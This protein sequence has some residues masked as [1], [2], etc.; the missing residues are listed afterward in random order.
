MREFSL[1]QKFDVIFN[2]FT[3]FGYF[4]K[5]EENREVLR[6]VQSHLKLNGHL[7]LDFLNVDHVKSG[8][9]SSEIKNLDGIDFHIEKKI[10]DGIIVKRIQ[11]RDES[12]KDHTYHERVQALAFADFK[13]I[14]G[15]TGM[16]IIN[17]FGDYNLNPFDPGTSERLILIAQ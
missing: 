2:L 15:D 17:T 4:E 16:K 11:F 6:Q 12:G 13:E 14:L 8:L 3:S 10:E 1:D 7:V 5:K 9:P